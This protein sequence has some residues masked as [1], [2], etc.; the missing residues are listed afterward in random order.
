[1]KYAPL[2]WAALWRKPAESILT[3]LAV[4]AA[5]TLFGIMI[6]LKATY[7]VVIDTA[8]LDR[9]LVNQKFP[10][11]SPDGMPI[12]LAQTLAH[13]DGVTAVG[14]QRG[15]DAYYQGRKNILTLLGVDEGM[16]AAWPEIPLTPA[17]W[18]RLSATPTGVYITR[19]NAR[20]LH[21]KNGDRMPLVPVN[22][23]AVGQASL[24]LTV[25]GVMDDYAQWDYRE[26]LANFRYLDSL[27][28]P[29]HRGHVWGFRLAVRDPARAVDIG[30]NIDRYFAN[31]GSPTRSLPLKL[32]VQTSANFGLPIESITWTVG[33][34]GLFVVL[35][36]VGNAIAES[37]DERLPEF[38]VLTTIGYR[39]TGLL[40]LV[41][42]E[43][44][45]PCLIGAILGSALAPW[46]SD[47]PRNLI[48][49]GFGGLPPAMF[50]SQELSY[51]IAFALLLSLV[52]ST[53]PLLKLRRLDVA[54]AMAER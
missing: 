33:I 37:V 53:A 18:D 2:V 44:L 22:A 41:F 17:Q 31:S 16:R 8:R 48:P 15:M 25:L 43:A 52:A 11:S 35:L 47:I 20:R 14:A 36:L 12:A 54:A 34:A 42:V 3:L 1:M 40:A 10:D 45:I 28:T 4:T 7:Q 27:L 51:A 6:G 26:V 39:R 24:E 49:P 9:V 50:W 23:Q 19:A 21:L 30:R 46:L 5:F 32:N 29:D 13:F 38:A